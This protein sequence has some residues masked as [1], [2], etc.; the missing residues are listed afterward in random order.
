ML[1][2]HVVNGYDHVM[3][4]GRDAMVV[5]MDTVCGT[6][7]AKL[8]TE[9]L[10][11]GCSLCVLFGLHLLTPWEFQRLTRKASA[12]NWKMI[13]RYLDQ[14]LSHFVESYTD[15]DGEVVV[16]FWILPQSLVQ[17][18][19][20]SQPTLM[21]GP[22]QIHKLLAPLAPPGDP[23]HPLACS[24]PVLFDLSSSNDQSA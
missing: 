8:H 13:I 14:P 22:R 24:Q 5:I 2:L 18:P 12:R 7:Q 6:L 15:A 16:G 10:S 20:V 1:L 4:S 19:N 23:V 17:P 3:E 21:N 11:S 9:V